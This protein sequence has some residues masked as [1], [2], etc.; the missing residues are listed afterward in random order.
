MK[1]HVIA[2]DKS[3]RIDGCGTLNCIHWRDRNE[4][5]A[6]IPSRDGLVDETGIST[7]LELRKMQRH[8]CQHALG[9]I[10]DRWLEDHVARDAG[11]VFHF[12]QV[13]SLQLTF[14]MKFLLAGLCK[15]EL[16]VKHNIAEMT[17]SMS[18]TL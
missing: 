9:E 13:L 10:S 17:S 12:R 11:I 3:F 14:E 6:V 5:A 16:L 15:P 18:W 4:A 1:E 7:G 2:V 8:R